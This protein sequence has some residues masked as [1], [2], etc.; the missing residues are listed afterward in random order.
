MKAWLW[1]Q[2]V[3]LCGALSSTQENCSTKINGVYFEGARITNG[4]RSDVSVDD[5]IALCDVDR[6]CH[7]WTWKNNLCMLYTGVTTQKREDGAISGRCP[8]PGDPNVGKCLSAASGVPPVPRFILIG[9]TGVGKST[10]AKRLMG[11]T[12]G[13]Y[14]SANFNEESPECPIQK[15][16]N[17]F[18]SMTKDTT[19]IAGKWLGRNGTDGLC[20]AVVDTP[21]IGDTSGPGKDCENFQGVAE[22]ARAIS[23]IDAF[24]LVIKGDQARVKPELLRHL[25]FFEELFGDKF[26]DNTIIAVSFWSHSQRDV[27]KRKKNRGGLDEKMFK[28]KLR[29][30]LKNSFDNLPPIPTV[31]IDPVYDDTDPEDPRDARERKWFDQ[32]TK[33]LWELITD[34]DKYECADS[35]SSPTFLQGTPKLEGKKVVAQRLGGQ[36]SFKWTIWFGDCDN[37]GA[38]SFTIIKDNEIIY[39]LNEDSYIPGRNWTPGHITVTAEKP[40][41]LQI[42]DTCSNLKPNTLE[43]DNDKT[44][45][46]TVTLTFDPL[47]ESGLGKYKIKN[48]KGESE[49]LELMAIVDG[50]VTQWGPWGACSKTC[51]GEDMTMG[52]RERRRTASEPENGGKPFNGAMNDSTNCGNRFCE[53]KPGDWSPW[54]ACSKSCGEGGIRERS[55]TCKGY[56]CP[57]TRQSKNCSAGDDQA[58]W[59]ERCP[60]VS[61]YTT[62][63]PWSCNTNCFNPNKRSH[64]KMTRKRTCID[65]KPVPHRDFNCNIMHLVKETVSRCTTEPEGFMTYKGVP[66]L[67]GNP[68]EKLGQNYYWCRTGGA[69]SEWDYC[70]TEK[71]FTRYGKKCKGPCE[72]NGEKYYWCT[73]SDSWDYCSPRC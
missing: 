43:C 26:W 27:R 65:D 68:C 32:E 30:I 64:T 67:P 22:M 4:F 70:S 50:A 60:V 53:S 23:P 40:P 1:L 38:R 61:N 39:T 66:C 5:C 44:K 2:A 69:N 31:F 16:G 11:N 49:E 62:W 57:E 59:L 73:T 20:F 10:L 36:V 35:C 48:I 71:K 55:R 28:G 33:K 18:T 25:R 24:V 58:G 72:K 9:E 54:T 12:C 21:G 19:W 46:K 56:H 45:Y 47:T 52:S 34:G 8:V 29:N 7:A 15:V 3:I 41:S 6:D 14:A 51:I 13:D 63:S 37:N 42:V 17:D